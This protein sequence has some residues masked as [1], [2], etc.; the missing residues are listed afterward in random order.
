LLFRAKK[1]N[2][3][4]LF[5]YFQKNRKQ[6]TKDRD[7]LLFFLSLSISLSLGKKGAIQKVDVEEAFILIY[8]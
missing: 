3:R 6:A 1:Q 8:I 2:T 7:A 5:F 4:T